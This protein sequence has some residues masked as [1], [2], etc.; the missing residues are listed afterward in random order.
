MRYDV[1]S[2]KN[3]VRPCEQLFGCENH[4]RPAARAAPHPTRKSVGMGKGYS[5]LKLAVS[6]STELAPYVYPAER[7]E[8]NLCWDNPPVPPPCGILTSLALGRYLWRPQFFWVFWPLPPCPHLVQINSTKST[9][10]HLLH[11]LLAQPPFP[12][13]CGRHKWMAPEQILQWH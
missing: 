11:L 5:P 2:R 8:L 3:T 12:P 1:A 13:P 9:Q 4:P 10:H 6:Y 7:K